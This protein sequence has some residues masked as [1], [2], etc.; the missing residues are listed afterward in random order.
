MIIEK[1]KMNVIAYHSRLTKSDPDVH[2]QFK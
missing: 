1:K 2:H